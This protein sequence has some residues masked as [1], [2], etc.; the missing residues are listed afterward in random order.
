MTKTLRMAELRKAHPIFFARGNAEIFGD[1]EY[2]IL[3]SKQGV[4]HL[5]RR[6]QQWSDMFG[7]NPVQCWR[8]NPISSD[9]DIEDLVEQQFHTLSDVKEWLKNTNQ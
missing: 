4:P 6:T 5:V 9:L 2:R 1:R 7:N 3:H 8:V